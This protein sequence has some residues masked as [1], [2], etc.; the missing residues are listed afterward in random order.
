MSELKGVSLNPDDFTSE[1]EVEPAPKQDTQTGATETPPKVRDFPL[2]LSPS[3]PLD[4]ASRF[5][6]E[7]CTQEGLR[8]LHFFRGDFYIWPVLLC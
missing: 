1:P 7:H 3:S 5:I 6:S 4:S 8:T 2:I